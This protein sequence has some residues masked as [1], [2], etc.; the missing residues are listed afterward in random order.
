MTPATPDTR[1]ADVWVCRRLRDYAPSP[2]PL[3]SGIASCRNCGAAIV[4]NPKRLAS[5]PP[6]TPMICMQCAHIRPL[7]IES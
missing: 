1:F 5:V 6:E 3:D 2:V 7:P 4:F